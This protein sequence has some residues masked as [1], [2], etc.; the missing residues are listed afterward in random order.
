MLL[1]CDNGI[2]T[3]IFAFAVLFFFVFFFYSNSL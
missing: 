3:T 1:I 2:I